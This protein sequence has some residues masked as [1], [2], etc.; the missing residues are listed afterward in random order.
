[1][2]RRNK[3][4]NNPFY[5]SLLVPGLLV[6][7]LITAVPT[8]MTV[9]F[10]FT[11]LHLYWPNSGFV[12]FKNYKDLLSLGSEFYRSLYLDIVWTVFS[13]SL[14]LIFALIGAIA[15][16]Q[17]FKES[18]FFRI[19]LIIP[20]TFPTISLAFLWKWMLEPSL[21]IVNALL[22]SIGLLDLPVN[23]FGSA[24]LAFPSVIG[25]NVWFGIPF[26]MVTIIAGLQ[27]ISEDIYEAAEIDGTSG[28]QTLWHITLPSLKR[29]IMIA[30]TLR[31]IWIFNNFDFIFMT[32]GGGPSDRTTILPVLI[33]KLG[34][35]EGW[36]G[37]SAAVA[38]LALF[39]LM[40]NAVFAL[41]ITSEEK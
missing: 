5:F 21:G 20:W 25:M 13:V 2:K 37:K 1:M 7:L 29:V 3:L 40:I 8:L 41:K 11:N 32:T 35:G 17:L 28:W 24:D 27:A 9:V 12:G 23:W 38:V 19:I 30:V 39:I 16:Q 33:Y 26:M 10:S 14:Q 34:W 36:L 18:I 4:S 6:L 22:V 15:L 31:I